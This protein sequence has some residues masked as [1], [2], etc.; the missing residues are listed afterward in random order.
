MKNKKNLHNPPKIT[1]VFAENGQKRFIHPSIR[2]AQYFVKNKAEHYLKNDN[3]VTIRVSYK[4]GG[5]NTGTY[6]T[7]SDL[8]W[9]FQAFVIEYLNDE[10]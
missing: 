7:I 1:F 9:A 4:K 3:Y 5:T 2:R 10:I 8:K 6:E